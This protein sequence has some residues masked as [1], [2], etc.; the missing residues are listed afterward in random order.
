MTKKHIKNIIAYCEIKGIKG[1]I[2]I[3]NAVRAY[4]P[5]PSFDIFCE[6]RGIKN[7]VHFEK[8]INGGK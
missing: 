4:T 3:Y 8:A 6:I 2:N 7:M 1:D 5:G